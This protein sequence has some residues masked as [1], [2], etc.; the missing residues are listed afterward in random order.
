[1]LY[2]RSVTTKRNAIPS[3]GHI[4]KVWPC[5][6]VMVCPI[7]KIRGFFDVIRGSDA[8]NI[9]YVSYHLEGS[10]FCSENSGKWRSVL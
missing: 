10:I 9:G 5:V 8:E 6:V 3:P 7:R 4:A 1:M 2:D